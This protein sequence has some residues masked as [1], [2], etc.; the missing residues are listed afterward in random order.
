MSMGGGCIRPHTQLG[1][2]KQVK[3]VK[4]RIERLTVIR[5]LHSRSAFVHGRRPLLFLAPRAST[6]YVLRCDIV[7]RNR[8]SRAQPGII[9]I[10]LHSTV[11][12]YNTHCGHSRDFRGVPHAELWLPKSLSPIHHP[13][14]PRAPPARWADGL[15]ETPSEQIGGTNQPRGNP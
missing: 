15:G 8:D 1:H 7:S 13:H 14:H 4:Q 5:C 10:H 9:S 3:R 12:Y 2:A 6:L 11:Q